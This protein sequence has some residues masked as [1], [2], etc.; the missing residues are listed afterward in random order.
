MKIK[1]T[2]KKVLM[3]VLA[4]AAMSGAV[5]W[6]AM[7]PTSD[8]ALNTVEIT[9]GDIEKTVLATGYLNRC[10]KSA[11]GRRSTDNCKSCM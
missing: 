3:A 4:L 5:V 8:G 2:G 10:C 9:R 1:M 6:Y 7:T 11:S